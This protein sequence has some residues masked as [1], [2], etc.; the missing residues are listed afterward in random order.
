MPG[1][2]SFGQPGISRAPCLIVTSRLADD[3]QWAELLNA[4]AFDLLAKPFEKSNV[5]PDRPIGLG[6]LAEPLSP[7]RCRT[8]N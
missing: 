8:A 5:D 6:T 4:G 1:G 2:K 7:Y 3:R